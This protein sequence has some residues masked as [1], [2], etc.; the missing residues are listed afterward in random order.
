MSPIPT[1][2]PEP[3]SSPTDERRDRTA[4]HGSPCALSRARTSSR[5][6]CPPCGRAR[7]PQPWPRLDLRPTGPRCNSAPSVTCRSAYRIGSQALTSASSAQHLWRFDLGVVAVEVQVLR[8]HAPPH[9]HRTAL[10]GPIPRT[11]PL[12][13]V[14]VEDRHEQQLVVRDSRPPRL[15][16]PSSISRSAMKPA[17]LPSISPAWMP[18]WKKTTGC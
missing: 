16:R 13:S 12:M 9:L 7:D 15:S 3:G 2:S 4:G 5:S 10:V 6:A 18:P 8:R 1:A 17:S 11:E 14:D